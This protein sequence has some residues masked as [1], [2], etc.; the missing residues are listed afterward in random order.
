MTAAEQRRILVEFATAGRE[1]LRRRPE[2]EPPLDYFDVML[3][4]EV[5]FEAALLRAGF[6]N[7]PGVPMRA[8]TKFVKLFGDFGLTIRDRTVF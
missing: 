1:L 6:R 3:R 8:I 7:P 5:G 2:Q 4:R